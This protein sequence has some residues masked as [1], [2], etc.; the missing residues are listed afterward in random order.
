[1]FWHITD[2]YNFFYKTLSA[3][4]FGVFT[5]QYVLEGWGVYGHE[6]GFEWWEISY[7]KILLY[8]WIAKGSTWSCY[9]ILKANGFTLPV[10]WGMTWKGGLN[11]EIILW[12]D[13]GLI[14]MAKGFTWSI[15]WKGG[16]NE[17]FGTRKL[18]KIL[19]IVR[20]LY[21]KEY[22]RLKDWGYDTQYAYKWLG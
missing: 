3:G 1:M 9:I 2:M 22:W 18:F 12:E 20:G 13:F 14:S 11:D 10:W 17:T 8:I 6:V 4:V 16:Q 15:W 7:E 5:I 21:L 19:I